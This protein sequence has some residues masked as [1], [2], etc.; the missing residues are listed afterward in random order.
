VIALMMTGVLA[1]RSGWLAEVP[2][3]QTDYLVVRGPKLEP[4]PAQGPARVLIAGRVGTTRLLD[5]IAVELGSAA[6]AGGA[7]A[8]ADNHRELPWRD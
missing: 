1:H 8:G 2:G 4:T 6:A 5:N 3:I 7:S